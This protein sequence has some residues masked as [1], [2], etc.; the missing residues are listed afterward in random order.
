METVELKR[1]PFCGGKPKLIQYGDYWCIECSNVDCFMRPDTILGDKESVIR[2]WQR[3]AD[4]EP[5]E[6]M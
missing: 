3:R 4:D 5:S 6:S 1:C 2:Q